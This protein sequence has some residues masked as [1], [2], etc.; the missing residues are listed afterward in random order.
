MTA[1]EDCPCGSGKTYET[2]CG[3]SHN[4]ISTVATAEGL[5]RSRYTAFVLENE[6]YLLQSWHP[7]TRPSHIDFDEQCKWLGLKIKSSSEGSAD[8][9]FGIVSFVARYK[10]G[11][12]AHRIVETSKFERIN[13][14][15]LY[16]SAL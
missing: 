10:I 1:L 2:C 15:W 14:V 9:D 11:G 13:G 8:D 6:A 3:T 4:D 5:M 16:H 12:K 7:D